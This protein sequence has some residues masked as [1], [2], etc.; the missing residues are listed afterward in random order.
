MSVIRGN[1]EFIYS[2]RVF[3]VLTQLRRGQCAGAGLDD[4][5]RWIDGRTSFASTPSAVVIRHLPQR[6]MSST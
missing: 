4:P 3:R 5:I 2:G 6:A 1:P